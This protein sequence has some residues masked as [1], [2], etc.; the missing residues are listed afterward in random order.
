[1]TDQ[2][3]RC[4]LCEWTTTHF[5]TAGQGL[6]YSGEVPWLLRQQVHMLEHIA[7][8]VFETAATLEVLVHREGAQERGT[9]AAS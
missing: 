2:V 3:W 4:E 1:M 9:K 7:C 5:V 8:S 6:P